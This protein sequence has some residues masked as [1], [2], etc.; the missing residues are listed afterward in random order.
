MTQ[1][2]ER[3]RILFV[4][5]NRLSEAAIH[6]G[7]VEAAR[8]ADAERIEYVFVLIE[9]PSR[10]EYS[11]RHAQQISREA[12]QLR[13]P[14][15][16]V[17]SELWEQYQDL[18]LARARPLSDERLIRSLLDTDR[19][20]Y[21][22]APNKVYLLAAA[23]DVSVIHRRDSDHVPDLLGDSPRFP[24]ELEAAAIG[25]TLAQ[26]KLS[27]APRSREYRDEDVVYLAASSMYGE[28]PVDR[29]SLVSCGIEHLYALE[30]VAHPERSYWDVMARV[31]SYYIEEPH[32]RYEPDF[33]SLDMTGRSEI[34]V[35]CMKD[36]FLSLPE[37]PMP[38]TLGTDYMV[39]NSMYQLGRPVIFHSRKMHHVYDVD[40]QAPTATSAIDYAMSDLRFLLLRKV[41]AAH[42]KALVA[43]RRAY[44]LPNGAVNASAYA[45]N[46]RM[47]L[48][49]VDEIA[50]G[51]AARF[52]AVYRCAG[53]GPGADAAINR[54]IA[55]TAE[56]MTAEIT[57]Q[58]AS[59]LFEYCVLVDDWRKLVVAAKETGTFV[60]DHLV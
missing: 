30:Q 21:G 51:L 46:L 11:L 59:G 50:S 47:T 28:P 43:D 57:H 45:S 24:G 58:V 44:L 36:T 25:R 27:A 48:Y 8:L 53:A 35:S 52:A 13:L 16:H 10:S 38:E 9:Q 19:K 17:T 15:F 26:I 4:P 33:L 34:G 31:D 56:A 54:R 32:T 60:R 7:I 14:A 41:L 37:L 39:K 2:A 20:A 40:R 12:A 49:G 22:V 23:L 18:M 42:N 5:T 1:D 55:A 29:R 6:W 3:R